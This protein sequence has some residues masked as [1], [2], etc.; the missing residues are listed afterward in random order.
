MT[1]ETGVDKAVVGLT[2]VVR[3]GLVEELTHTATII[4][5]A[6]IFTMPIFLMFRFLVS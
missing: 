3:P 2:G 1:A 5:P 6:F 4:I